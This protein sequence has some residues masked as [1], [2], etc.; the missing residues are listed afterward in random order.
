MRLVAGTLLL[1]GPFAMA[2]EPPT[3]AALTLALALVG[4]QE[5]VA[6]RQ[7]SGVRSQESGVGNQESGVGS[8]E[9]TV[10]RSPCHLPP[11]ARPSVKQQYSPRRIIYLFPR[12][13]R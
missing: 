4:R 9:S 11:A 3:D 13:R 6:A 10:N 12:L 2:G 8:Q 7:E 5:P 1:C